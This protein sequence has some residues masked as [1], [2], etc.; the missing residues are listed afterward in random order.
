HRLEI[1]N[2]RAL[3]QAEQV[4]AENQRLRELLG[5][6]ERAAIPS[7]IAEVLYDTRDPYSRRLVLDK[8]LQHGLLAGQPVIDARGVIGQITRVLPLSSEVTLLTDRNATLPVELQRT[9][10]RAIAFG[11]GN[12]GLL[13]LRFLAASSDI[14]AGDNVVTSGLDGVYPPG[15]P[16]GK[17]ARLEAPGTS[18][19]FGRVLIAPTAAIDRSR[20]MLVLLVDRQA[21]PPPPSEAPAD[22]R[23]RK[24]KSDPS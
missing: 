9:G 21:L 17:V 1:A 2:S 4:G 16:V 18:G 19:I 8:G 6:R 22:N 5:A 11:G 3:L 7:V 23:K 13:D 12:D 24:P 15:L 14:K 20:L 10:Q